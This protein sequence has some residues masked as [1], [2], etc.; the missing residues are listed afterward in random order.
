MQ[1]GPNFQCGEWKYDY[2]IQKDQEYF[3]KCFQK[4][5]REGIK[6][7][8]IKSEAVQDF[9]D[10]TEAYFTKAVFAQNLV[11]PCTGR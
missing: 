9:Y 1:P 5:Q 10:F 11:S 8:V 4:I 3:V 6:S 7:M 2:R